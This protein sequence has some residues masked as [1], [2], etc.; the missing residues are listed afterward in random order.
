M[1]SE[2][3]RGARLAA[4]ERHL[5]LLIAHLAGRAVRARVEVDD[6]VQEVFLR[7]LTAPG[8]LPPRDS[9]KAGETALRRF[10]A[11]VARNTVIDAARAIRAA[12]RQG[13]VERIARSEWTR[14]GAPRLRESQIAARTPG[15]STRVAAAEEHGLVVAA[16][17]QLAPDHR[18]VLG[19]RR[20]EGLS[21]REAAEHMGR[22]ETAIH[23][24]YRRALMAWEE[25]LG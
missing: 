1:C 10:L 12:K 11:R 25:A 9:D 6:L 24:L 3:D 23:S 21:A 16:F 8:G 14:V 19:L 2:S 17:E 7:A 22:S 20:F 4:Q 5:R 13:R 18:R 15:P